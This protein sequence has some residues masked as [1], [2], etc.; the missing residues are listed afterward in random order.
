M[1]IC[2]RPCPQPQGVLPAALQTAGR[3]REHTQ[4][5]VQKT[6]SGS[7]NKPRDRKRSK[8]AFP[9]RRSWRED[10][11]PL[12]RLPFG[13]SHCW[14]RRVD[15]Q[16]GLSTVLSV[17]MGFKFPCA[18][19]TNRREPPARLPAALRM[20]PPWRPRALPTAQCPGL[21]PSGTVDTCAEDITKGAGG[22]RK[23]FPLKQPLI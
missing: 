1:K 23:S 17:G 22:V 15:E 3:L 6:P 14:L 9:D 16:S 2:S 21:S 19:G 20:E 10:S 18:R 5:R 4:G 8:T 7:R 13:H 12:V 11:G